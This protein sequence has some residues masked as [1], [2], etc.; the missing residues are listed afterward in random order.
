MPELPE[1]ET[2]RQDL[3]KKVLNTKMVQVVV[4]QGKAVRGSA[5][6]LP[7]A[8]VGKKIEDVERVGKLLMF[9]F[10]QG[11]HF[12]LVHLK[13]TGQL[14]YA[15]GK[16]IVA[17]GHSLTTTTQWSLP[18]KHTQISIHF[19]D[20]GTLYFNDMRRFGYAR[21]LSAVDKEAIVATYGIE[22]LTTQF[23]LENFSKVLTHR[24]TVLKALLL[25][26]DVIAGIG[27]IYAD[28]ICHKA[29]VLP[30][31]KT[32]SVSTSEIKALYA[33]TKKIIALAIKE[34]GTTF[35]NYVDSEG[36]AGNFVRFLKVYERDGE[37]CL[38]CK[39]GLILKKTVA[40]RGTHYCV[41]CQF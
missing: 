7:K 1:V 40:G 21:I 41:K 22:P 16:K 8:L 27:N 37:K 10:D 23:T 15:K 25:R 17:G 28:E 5:Q 34:R 29:H 11:K 33:A 26:Q 32:N 13:M 31:R 18:D 38:T 36:K 20:G 19:A 30:W 35:N 39:K 6:P 4:L 12:L 14:I 9:R 24:A 2:I 3:R